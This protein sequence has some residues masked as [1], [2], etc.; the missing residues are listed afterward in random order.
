MFPTQTVVNRE[1]RGGP[2]D[3]R[4]KR[5]QAILSQIF[6]PKVDRPL[7]RSYIIVHYYTICFWE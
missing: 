6:L 2:E 7:Q 1:N 4:G 5:R 3:G